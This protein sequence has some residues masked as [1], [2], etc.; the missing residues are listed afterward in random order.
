MDGSG[1]CIWYYSAPKLTT[2]IFENVCT[3]F[4]SV[5]QSQTESFTARN[6]HS[7]TWQWFPYSR[8]K[9]YAV[10]SYIIII[11]MIWLF[12]NCS[13]RAEAQACSVVIMCTVHAG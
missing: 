3:N 4:T 13:K 11:I 7:L 12:G 9:S 2:N 1:S 5:R 10:D 6:F 8:A